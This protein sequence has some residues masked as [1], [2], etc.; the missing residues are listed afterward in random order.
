MCIC[1]N[2]KKYC[3]RKNIYLCVYNKWYIKA[4]E[5][6]NHPIMRRAKIWNTNKCMNFCYENQGNEVRMIYVLKMGKKKS[7]KER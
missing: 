4:N 1:I 7:E 6:F 3:L 5:N 2:N